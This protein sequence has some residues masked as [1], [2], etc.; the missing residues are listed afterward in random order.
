MNV[1]TMTDQADSAVGLQHGERF[2]RLLMANQRRIYAFVLSLVHDPAAADD[3]LQEVLGV[4]WRKFDQFR[5]ETD[6][7]AWAM[8][9]ARLSVFEWR[10]RQAK[11]PLPL[12]DEELAI[13]A[14]EAEQLSGEFEAR[15]TA[16]RECLK[17]LGDKERRL[18]HSRYFLNESVAEMAAQAKYTPRAVYRALNKV[19]AMLLRCVRR[20]M[21]ELA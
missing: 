21:E 2:T 1:L 9:A 14:D 8:S 20:T 18:L 15:Q 4:L 19:H 12:T 11:L 16:L 13:L 5:E 7:A 17:K 3:V 6:F 10:R